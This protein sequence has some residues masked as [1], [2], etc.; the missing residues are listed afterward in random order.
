LGGSWFEVNLGKKLR[1]SIPT[2]KKVGVVACTCHQR[3]VGSIKRGITVH[4]SP[5]TN[6]RP[7]PQNKAKRDSCITQVI[8]HLPRKV[9]A[10][11]SNPS[12]TR[13]KKV[14]HHVNV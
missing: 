6:M 7:Y 1:D 8:K 4:A 12:T 3:Y 9:K 5:G 14:G 11:R 2:I 13:R 10:L